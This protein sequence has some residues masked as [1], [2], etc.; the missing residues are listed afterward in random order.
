MSLL[1]ASRLLPRLLARTETVEELFT[2][3]LFADGCAPLAHTEEALQLIV[4]RFSDAAN[5]FGLT[6]SL[7]KTEVLYQPHP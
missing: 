7:K 5:S 3:L 2:E 4:N 1:E 6:I